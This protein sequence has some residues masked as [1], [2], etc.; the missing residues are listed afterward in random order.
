MRFFD[1]SDV[2]SVT[3]PYLVS[4]RHMEGVYDILN[5]LTGDNLFTHQLPRACRESQDWLRTQYPQLMP[6]DLNMKLA[7]PRLKEMIA[8][9]SPQEGCARWVEM[10]RDGNGLPRQIPV[11][12]MGK[13]MHTRIDPIEEL[14]AMVGDEKVIVIG[15][16]ESE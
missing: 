16:E 9:S 12:A 3:T 8:E 14:R 13:G 2:L 11:H 5:F 4:S 6:D 7:I 15:R 1:I 10:I